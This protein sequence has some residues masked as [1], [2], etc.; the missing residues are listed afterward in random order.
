MLIIYI[1]AFCLFFSPN[2]VFFHV[3]NYFNCNSGLF[4]NNE[5]PISHGLINPHCYT[6]I[7]KK[8]HKHVDCQSSVHA[9]MCNTLW[10]CKVL[11][12]LCTTIIC[13]VP[14]VYY[15]VYMKLCLHSLVC[16]AELWIMCLLSFSCFTCIRIYCVTINDFEFEFEIWIWVKKAYCLSNGFRFD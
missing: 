12:I 14:T 6:N 5:D 10:D 9:S 11:S 16:L 4:L 15:Y 13:V 8:R 2:L 3:I 1:N 7:T